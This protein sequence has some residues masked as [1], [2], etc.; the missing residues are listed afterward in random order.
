MLDIKIGDTLV[1]GSNEY[2][3]RFVGE[4]VLLG[5]TPA[6]QR[7]TS[8][9]ASTKRPAIASGQRTAAVTSIASLKCTP[10]DPAASDLAERI[11]TEIPYT[12]LEC[13][14]ADTAD[15]VRLALEKVAR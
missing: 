2:A 15:Y 5:V 4:W 8:Q 6:F 13:F 12:L 1:V 14:A 9:T 10:V 7:M 11:S 3:I